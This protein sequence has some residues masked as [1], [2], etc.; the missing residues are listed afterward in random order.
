MKGWN[1]D[2]S[3]MNWRQ[4]PEH[5]GAIH[6]HDD[7][8]Y[9]AAWQADFAWT[10]PDGTRS[11]VYAAHLLS[12]D[13]NHEDYLPFCVRPPR[14][15]ATAEIAVLLPTASYLAYANDHSSMDAAAAEMVTGRLIVLQPADL[16]IDAHR[17]W[18]LAL[19]D[20]HSDGSGVCYSSWH[21]PILNLRPKYASWLGGAGSGLWQFNADTHLI[22]WL[23]EK[24]FAYD[25]ITDEDLEAEGY[26]CAPPAA[27]QSATPGRRLSVLL[28]R[29]CDV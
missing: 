15:R 23:E 24:G 3:E 17:E 10:V 22:D 1:W 8:I 29:S 11:G 12:A 9:D 26:P 5:Y 21:R 28:R 27:R 7:D 18:G 20:T 13:G 14:G 6:F 19:Y 2:G 4:K 25:V 16:T